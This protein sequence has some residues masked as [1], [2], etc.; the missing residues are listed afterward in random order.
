MSEEVKIISS[1]EVAQ[2]K[3]TG[4]GVWIIVHDKVYDVTKFLEEVSCFLI[5]AFLSPSPHS[6][7]LMCLF[8]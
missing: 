4:A 7:L 6:L 8:F 3:D 5:T 2:H 1:A